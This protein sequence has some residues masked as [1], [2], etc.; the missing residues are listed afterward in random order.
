MVESIM[1]KAPT[2]D[3]WPGQT[4]EAEL[5]LTYELIDNILYDIEQQHL[6]KDELYK[7]YDKESV[8]KIIKRVISNSFKRRTPFICQ[9]GINKRCAIDENI[10]LNLDK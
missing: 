4:D 1:T 5:G 9:S 6:C 2:A 10:F 8:D 7:K 3:L